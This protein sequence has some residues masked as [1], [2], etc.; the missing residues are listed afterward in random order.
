M[1]DDEQ[2][3]GG[4]GEAVGADLLLGEGLEEDELELEDDDHLQLA[5]A[6][7]NGGDDGDGGDGGALPTAADGTAA[8]S[9][10]LLREQR[11]SQKEWI[12]SL[13]V[14]DLRD[15]LAKIK[16]PVYG[17]KDELRK[18]LNQGLAMMVG[19]DAFVLVAAAAS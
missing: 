19:W 13:R 8:V 15:E 7:P 2:P 4:R 1:V 9:A 18:R 12:D 17:K 5:A 16:M 11:I 14:V 6:S 3:A 10:S